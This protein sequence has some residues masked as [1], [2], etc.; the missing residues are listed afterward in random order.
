MPSCRPQ[1]TQQL[2]SHHVHIRV[3][4]EV[5]VG[6]PAKEHSPPHAQRKRWPFGSLKIPESASL[7]LISYSYTMEISI[8][9]ENV[10]HVLTAALFLNIAPVAQMCWDFVERHL[11]AS[12]CLLVHCMAE[13]HN[14]HDLA[15]KSRTIVLRHFVPVSQSVDFLLVDAEKISELI[16]CDA[17]HVE[18]EDEVFHAVKRWFDH[19]P[20]GRKQHLSDIMQFVRVTFLDPQCLEEYF[21]ALLNGFLM[22]PG[23]ESSIRA[24]NISELPG[25]RG[26]AAASRCRPRESYGLPKLIV[27]LGGDDKKERPLDEVVVFSPSM[28]TISCLKRLP[29]TVTHCG[30][31]V[32]DDTSIFVCGGMQRANMDSTQ[33][34]WRY[35][36]TSNEWKD[37]A[38]MIHRRSCHGVAALNGRIYA[39]GGSHYNEIHQWSKLYSVECFNPRRNSWQLMPNLPLALEDVAMVAF[40]DR[41]YL[42]GG[43]SHSGISNKVFC[44]DPVVEA[45]SQMADM[46][47]GRRWCTACVGPKELIY[48]MGGNA[49]E[50]RECLR[51]TEAFDPSANKWLKKGNII[52]R[53]NQPGS[54]FVDGKMYIFGGWSKNTTNPAAS[55]CNSSIEVYDEAMDTWTLHGVGLPKAK[56]AFG[57]AVIALKKGMRLV[58]SSG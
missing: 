8:H 18:K 38:P 32:L 13:K 55:N 42:F 53:R 19:D 24:G 34:V 15:E 31:A 39:V 14:N 52:K 35:D 12:S 47:T 10:Q 1:R 43:E 26:E 21:L 4:R 50:P 30:V 36:A 48:V 51:C 9:D 46:P 45:W 41:L 20:A 44:Y 57:C 27:C 11:D 40:K 25:R 54:A 22:A 49:G 23:A 58:D 5:P 33:E 16:E 17:L 29:G 56:S 28:S 2:F 3:E 7:W 37:V 6:D